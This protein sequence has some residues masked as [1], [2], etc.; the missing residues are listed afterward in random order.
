M[1]AINGK[2][3]LSASLALYFLS[4]ENEPEAIIMV[5]VKRV[6]VVKSVCSCTCH[7]FFFFCTIES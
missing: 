3:L 6:V 2:I 5:E 1:N 4:C 7:P